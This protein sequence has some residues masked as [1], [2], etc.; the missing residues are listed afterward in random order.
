MQTTDEILFREKLPNFT[1]VEAATL[2]G[3]YGRIIS[4]AGRVGPL[5]DTVLVKFASESG[6]TAGPL[7]LTSLVAK[8]LC[9]LLIDEGFGPSPQ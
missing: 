5:G 6:L 3:K 2:F 1:D 8:E 4:I 7:V 9:K